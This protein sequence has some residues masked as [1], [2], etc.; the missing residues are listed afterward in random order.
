[1]LSLSRFTLHMG[2]LQWAVNAPKRGCEVRAS[3]AFIGLSLTSHNHVVLY[4]ITDCLQFQLEIAA[5]LS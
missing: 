5:G 3:W 4:L 2:H 1:M